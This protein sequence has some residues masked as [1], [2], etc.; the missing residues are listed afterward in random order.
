MKTKHQPTAWKH[1]RLL[2]LEK[3]HKM[4]FSEEVIFMLTPNVLFF[5]IGYPKRKL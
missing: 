4:T 5:S 2:L 1:K 3:L